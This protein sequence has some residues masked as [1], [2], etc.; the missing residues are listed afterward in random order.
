MHFASDMQHQEVCMNAVDLR[1][2]NGCT[3]EE[4]ASAICLQLGCCQRGAMSVI[5]NCAP[6]CRC[7]MRGLEWQCQHIRSES[8]LIDE[9][10]VTHDGRMRLT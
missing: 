1:P 5:S 6:Q 7:G 8:V 2:A 10:R 3:G 9:E 4:I